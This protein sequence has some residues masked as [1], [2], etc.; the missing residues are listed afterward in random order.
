MGNPAGQPPFLL[1][2][3]VSDTTSSP[4]SELLSSPFQELPVS[5]GF[6]KDANIGAE[7]KTQAEVRIG[8][9]HREIAL[10]H[11]QPCKLQTI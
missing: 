6:P 10:L 9:P 5:A 8:A 7:T 1:S 4:G 2:L 3:L 11:L